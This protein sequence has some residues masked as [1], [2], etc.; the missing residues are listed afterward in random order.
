M[1]VATMAAPPS[2][3][4]LWTGRALSTIP[5]LFLVL[6]GAMKVAQV[7]PVLEVSEK[8]GI[9]LNVIPGLGILLI[10]I[11]LVYA[12][13]RTSVLGAVLLTGYLGG[14]VSAHVRVN[15]PAFPTIFPCLIAG[16]IW[17][18][19]LLR[20]PRLRA[21]FPLRGSTATRPQPEP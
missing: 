19:L 13:P 16:L 12:I 5:V 6:D 15:D 20:E 7:K 14:A 17:G 18:G 10:A 1:A 21:L 8:M 2:K 3:A 4:V 11:T 9:P